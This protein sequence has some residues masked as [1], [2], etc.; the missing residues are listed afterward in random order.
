MCKNQL[1]IFQYIVNYVFEV[2]TEL[3]KFQEVIF[4][5]EFSIS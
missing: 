4:N 3:A 5:I 1:F 2:E